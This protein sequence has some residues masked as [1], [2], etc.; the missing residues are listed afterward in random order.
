MGFLPAGTVD[1]YFMSFNTS[2]VNE[3]SLD[4]VAGIVLATVGTLV[5]KG[6]ELGQVRVRL[7]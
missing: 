5:T 3:V 2:I 1:V 6:L 4:R 7:G